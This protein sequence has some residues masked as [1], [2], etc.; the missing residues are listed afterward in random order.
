MEE[1]RVGQLRG[2]HQF[3][4]KWWMKLL[5]APEVQ[6]AVVSRGIE[7][8][9][10]DFQRAAE[11]LRSVPGVDR[12]APCALI[13]EIG[14]GMSRFPGSRHLASS[15]GLCP[16]NGQ[17]AG[18][19]RSGRSHQGN[20]WIETLAAQMAWVAS[21]NK[22]TCFAALYRGLAPHQGR[23]RALIAVANSLLEAAWFILARRQSC[24]DPGRRFRAAPP[25]EDRPER[26]LPDGKVRVS[27]RVALQ[28][29]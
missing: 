1:A 22:N 24:R 6:V 2:R 13:G 25:R 8:R 12:T 20:R 19:N 18:H 26:G 16:G 27:D 15:A 10:Q 17:S 23:K 3:L 9:M 29:A 7:R 21:R 5:C 14:A 11:L 28:P 4:R